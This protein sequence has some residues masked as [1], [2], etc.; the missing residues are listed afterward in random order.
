MPTI[1]VFKFFLSFTVPL[2]SKLTRLKLKT[3]DS[4]LASRSLNASSFEMQGSSLETGGSRF[5]DQ[6]S[7][8]Q[9]AR[10]SEKAMLYSHV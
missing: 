8:I 2:K 5:G 10:F 9:E 4:I 6:G 7:R 3:R 1:L